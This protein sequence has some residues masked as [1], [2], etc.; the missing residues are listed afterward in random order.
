MIDV[1][2]CKQSYDLPQMVR[3]DEYNFMPVFQ[4]DFIPE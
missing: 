3:I 4:N 1:Y 2:L